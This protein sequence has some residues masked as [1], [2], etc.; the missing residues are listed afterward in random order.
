MNDINTINNYIKKG[1]WPKP[2]TQTNKQAR[3][4]N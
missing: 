1:G 4:K 2:P 3:L